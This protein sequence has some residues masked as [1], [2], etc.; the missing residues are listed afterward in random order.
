MFAGALTALMS[1]LFERFQKSK[2][3]MFS[4][5]N[6]RERWSEYQVVEEIDFDDGW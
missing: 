2:P 6:H 5:W 3:G 1:K 4:T